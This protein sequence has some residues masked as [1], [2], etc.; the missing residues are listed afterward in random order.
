ME[1]KGIADPEKS[2]SLKRSHVQESQPQLEEEEPREIKKMKRL[3]S[4]LTC[5]MM[6]IILA[7]ELYKNTLQL[8][9]H[10]IHKIA[11]KSNG[12]MNN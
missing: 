4:E 7:P 6:H 5:T 1:E 3:T 10:N 12:K 9:S 2:P 8:R 11:N